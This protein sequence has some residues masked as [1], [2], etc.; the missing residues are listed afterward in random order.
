MGGGDLSY[1]GVISVCCCCCFGVLIGCCFRCSL[2]RSLAL[3]FPLSRICLFCLVCV[4][5]LSSVFFLRTVFFAS[6]HVFSSFFTD[7]YRYCSCYTTERATGV[8]GV[9]GV[10]NNP[11][12]QNLPHKNGGAR[13]SRYG[14]TDLG[15]CISRI[16]RDIDL[17]G[18]ISKTNTGVLLSIR[19]QYW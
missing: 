3:L 4:F 19:H 7:S 8:G 1:V 15:R 5:P 9:A 18:R 6:H 14:P 2:A 16:F 10:L 13:S 12:T 17:V 11:K